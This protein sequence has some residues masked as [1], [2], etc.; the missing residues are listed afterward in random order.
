MKRNETYMSMVN[1]LSGSMSK[2]RFRIEILWGISKMFDLYDEHNDFTVVFDNVCDIEIHIDKGQE[3][4]QIK[5]NKVASP[6]SLTYYLKKPDGNKNSIFGKLVILNETKYNTLKVALVS[7]AY[8]CDNKKVFK[9][10]E[11][12]L[13]SDLDTKYKKIIND[14]LKSEFGKQMNIDNFYYIHTSMNLENPESDLL[15]KT[16]LSFEKIK[17]CEPKKPNALYRLIVETAQKKAQYEFDSK[18]YNE[19]IKNKGF[20]KSEL[21]LMLDTY[22][23]TIDTSMEQVQKEIDKI[24]SISL[25]KK[26]NFA[27]IN[28]IENMNSSKELKK[29]EM[30]V[31]H[32]LN[33]ENDYPDSFNNLVDFLIQSYKQSFSIEMNEYDIKVFIMIVVKRWENNYYE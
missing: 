2:N 28:L 4:Y 22:A 16:I 27:M 1:D 6:K 12:F 14:K 5:S 31:V 9:D 19:L 7:N 33:D 29:I 20:T 30:D 8:L 21:D 13:I 24:D 10:F 3:Y 17:N 18:D 25:K 26:M 32:Y 11:E 23:D 15:G